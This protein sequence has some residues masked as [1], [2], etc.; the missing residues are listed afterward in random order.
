MIAPKGRPWA[1]DLLSDEDMLWFY[2][3]LF[4]F[5]L[6][7]VAPREGLP[8][9]SSATRADFISVYCIILYFILVVHDYSHGKAPGSLLGD[10]NMLLFVYLFCF[11]WFCLFLFVW[12]LLGKGS[13]WPAGRQ[14]LP[15]I[16]YYIISLYCILLLCILLYFI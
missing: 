15:F 7:I 4:Y 1:G 8:A 16:L 2:F 11:V 12:L 3:W 14:A 5:I 10:R 6:F 9:A 13:R